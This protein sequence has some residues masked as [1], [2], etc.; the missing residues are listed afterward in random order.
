LLTPS[1][2]R[3]V[4]NIFINEC[5]YLLPSFKKVMQN[6]ILSKPICFEKWRF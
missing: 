4:R 2:G 1:S 6:E 5:R 3:N